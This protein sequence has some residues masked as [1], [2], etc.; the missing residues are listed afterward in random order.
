[1]RRK[2]RWIVIVLVA[3][4]VVAL[5]QWTKSLVE[6]SLPVGGAIAPIPALA[7][8]FNIVHWLNTGAAFGILQGKASV[9]IVVAVVVIITIVVYARYLP[10][11]SLPITLALGFMLGG[12]FGNLVDRIRQDGQVTDFLLF[13]VPVGDRVYQWPAFNVADMSIVC[14][15][16][17]LG[18]MSF[19]AD[20]KKAQGT[21][22][23]GS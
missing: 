22:P 21:A 9:F 4:G 12:A 11:R 10:A 20:E 6:A 16:I 5:D 1:M 18:L 19:L 17:A 14:G 2:L 13:M 7:Q 8:N 15:T 23:S 3:M